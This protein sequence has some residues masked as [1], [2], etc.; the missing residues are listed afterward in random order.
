MCP[1][2]SDR[3]K[4]LAP[5]AR[6]AHTVVGAAMAALP[7][8]VG[9][10]TECHDRGKPLGIGTCEIAFRCY[11]RAALELSAKLSNAEVPVWG[12][13][14][15]GSTPVGGGGRP[16]RCREIKMTTDQ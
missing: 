1:I 13:V 7:A 5:R 14:A 4:A 6:M 12:S 11:K 16:H 2:Q 10:L 8:S 9:N 15:P 3:K